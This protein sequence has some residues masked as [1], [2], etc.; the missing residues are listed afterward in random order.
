M[1]LR[2]KIIEE[3]KKIKAEP[4]MK[5]AP[6][7]IELIE[8]IYSEVL[9]YISQEGR[10]AGLLRVLELLDNE[11][12]NTDT[13]TDQGMM[14]TIDIELTKNDF[15]NKCLAYDFD[16][17]ELWEDLTVSITRHCNDEV[18]LSK[19]PELLGMIFEWKVVSVKTTEE[20]NL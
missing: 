5:K 8:D 10:I 18:A 11:E 16:P 1:K 7:A 12:N 3:V 14:Y 4:L 15:E 13:D 17:G 19:L 9:D 6:T 2:E 20:D